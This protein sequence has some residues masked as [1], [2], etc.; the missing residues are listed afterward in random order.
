MEDLDM[1]Y[2]ARFLIAVLNYLIV[3]YTLGK[4]NTF[5]DYNVDD[6]KMNT[7]ITAHR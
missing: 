6:M 2:I 1:L 5:Q 3:R 4:S 7:E